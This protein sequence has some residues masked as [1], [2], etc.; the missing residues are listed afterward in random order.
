[1]SERRG[2]LRGFRTHQR[3][4]TYAI[5]PNKRYVKGR[6]KEYKVMNEARDKGCVALR[7]AGSHS[8]ID[9]VVVD[10]EHRVIRLIQCKPYTMVGSQ[11]DKL[12]RLYGALTGKYEVF[13]EVI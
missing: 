1:M 11:K 2:E 8:P 4:Y 7:S 12:Y 3:L 13:F 9:V 5:M 6:R 10:T